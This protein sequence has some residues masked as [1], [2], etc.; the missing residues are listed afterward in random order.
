MSRDEEG[1]EDGMEGEEGRREGVR[2]GGSDGRRTK[3]GQEVRKDGGN[4]SEAG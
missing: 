1:R 2:D 3:R 4:P